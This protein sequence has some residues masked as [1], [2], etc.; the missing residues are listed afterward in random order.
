MTVTPPA[1]M[2]KL[3]NRTYTRKEVVDI[4]R[5]AIGSLD[6]NDEANSKLYNELRVLVSYIENMR[7]EL[8]QMRSSEITKDHIP[9]AAEELD[10]VIAETAGATGT[11]MDAC[12]KVSAIAAEL[13]PAQGDELNSIVTNI[14]EAC[15]FQ[16]I[17]GQRIN[18][19][20]KTLKHIDMKVAEIIDAYSQRGV[21]PSLMTKLDPTKDSLLNGPQMKGA[22]STQEEIDA[23]LASFD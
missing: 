3:V 15:S 16:D 20:V 18:K 17:T 8:A 9:S 5:S 6:K 13:P 19:V 10:A 21:Q 23:L 22:A 2:P 1:E 7:T 11:I 4:I 14:Y 12:D